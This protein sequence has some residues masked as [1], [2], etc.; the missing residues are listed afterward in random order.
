MSGFISMN[1]SYLYVQ[2]DLRIRNHGRKKKSMSMTTCCAIDTNDGQCD[3]FV[4]G[5]DVSFIGAITDQASGMTAGTRNKPQ[6][7]RIYRF[8]I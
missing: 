4:F 1:G 6:I 3:H 5:L 2:R 7:E 8:I